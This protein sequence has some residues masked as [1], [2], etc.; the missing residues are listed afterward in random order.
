MPAGYTLLPVDV[1]SEETSF[2]ASNSAHALNISAMT[3]V[4]NGY[5]WE[6]WSAEG[7]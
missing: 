5:W 7:E 3:Q 6:S 4:G 1:P 2:V